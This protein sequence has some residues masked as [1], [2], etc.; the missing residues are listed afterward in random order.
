M[1][2]FPSCRLFILLFII[3][4][5][6]EATNYTINIGVITGDTDPHLILRSNNYDRVMRNYTDNNF[7]Y[8]VIAKGVDLWK[9]EINS[10]GGSKIGLDDRIEYNVTW[11]NTFQIT[12]EQLI[13]NIVDL[14]LY[15]TFKMLVVIGGN[16]EDQVIIADKC[17][18]TKK[19]IT[20]F[21]LQNLPEFSQC[22]VPWASN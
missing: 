10:L 12:P 21:P 7:L 2:L 8:D 11:F 5:V 15:G 20:A 13:I 18:T 17:E 3:G 22:M 6:A 14:E 16:D 4:Q 9:T 19:C 1:K